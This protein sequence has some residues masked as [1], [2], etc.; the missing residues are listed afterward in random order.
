[1][2][3]STMSNTSTAPI[4][5]NK[6]K[7]EARTIPNRLHA[8]AYSFAILALLYQH[9]LRLLQPHTTFLSFA[10]Y[11]SML[12]ADLL[13]AFM[14]ATNQG[15]RWRPVRRES[16]PENL[17]AVV[18]DGELP[19]LDL[20]ICTADP[21]KEPPMTAVNTALSVMAFDYP[22]E[23]VSVYV[24]DDGGSE[25]TLFAFMEAAKFARHW[26]PFCRDNR[27]QD[28]CPEMYFKSNGDGHEFYS[29]IKVNKSFNH[30]Y[31]I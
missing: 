1:M 23:K 16:L 31:I 8:I 10:L 2:S 26:L 7:V 4:S 27:I 22:A 17:S 25:L 19:E 30:R 21:Y 3:S 13:L 11:L 24:S 6:V 5:L 12:V 18:D 9:S 29:E 14:W 20:F 15:F 28:R